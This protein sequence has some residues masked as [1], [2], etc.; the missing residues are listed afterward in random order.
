MPMKNFI[1]K[2]KWLAFGS[3]IV[4]LAAFIFLVLPYA[5]SAYHLEAGGRALDQ[6][7]ESANQQISKSANQQ[8]AN[9]E[10]ASPHLQSAIGHL[11]SAIRWDARNSQAYRLLGRAYLAQ[12]DLVAAAEALTRFTELR[13]D[14]PLGHIELAGVYETMDAEL[15]AHTRY[16]FLAHLPEARIETA[17]L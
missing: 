3:V 6:I 13:P 8:I 14:N 12:G 16:D 2:S 10:W 1:P 5:A 17:G 11:Q 7:N 9:G 4:A 15:E